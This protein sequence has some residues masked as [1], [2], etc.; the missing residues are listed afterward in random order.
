MPA[1]TPP[2]LPLTGG[3]QCGAVRYSVAGLPI[4][5]YICHCTE[6]QKQSSSAFGES[7]RVR[8]EDLTAT[9]TL[10]SFERPS[11]SGPL[12]G[13]F[14]PNC[15]TRLFHAR[16]KY[17]ETLNIKAGSLD[18][19][20]W[21]HPAGHI[22]TKS[23]QPWVVLP[24]N[25][26]TYDRQPEDD[27]AA[28]IAKW[29]EMLSPSGSGEVADAALTLRKQYHFRPSPNG[30]YAWDVHRLIELSKDLPVVSIDPKDIAELNE[31]YWFDGQQA[32]PSCLDL[33]EHMRL[34]QQTDFQHPIILCADG[35]VMDGMHRVVR[36]VLENRDT[37]EA[38]RFATTPKPDYTDVQADDLP[39]D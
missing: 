14:C 16:G 21:L 27:D 28:L 18:D 19:T 9:G 29:Q 39:Y 24:E 36:A 5:F 23:K 38:V 34:V 2:R 1:L 8:R 32:N 3:C 15:G 17:A 4:V 26:L 6:C 13:E 35:R 33:L 31:S 25:A 30:Y 11:A 22:W 12:T 37:I 10:A 20:S 7:F